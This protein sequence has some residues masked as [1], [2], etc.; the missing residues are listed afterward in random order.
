MGVHTSQTPKPAGCYAD[1]F[2]IRK[3]YPAVVA[4]HD[5]LD[6][7]LA[8]DQH[9]DLTAGLVREFSELAC[10]LCSYDLVW[11][12]ASRIEFFYTTKLVRFES[13]RI[14]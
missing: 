6:V 7:A 9:S 5:V 11:R 8:I 1:A 4:N 12:D 2:E 3:L 14:A 10:K 13:K